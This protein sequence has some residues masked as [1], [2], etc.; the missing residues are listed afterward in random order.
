MRA[1]G[2]D[3]LFVERGEAPSFYDVDGNATSTSCAP[4]AADPRPTGAHPPFL[5]AVAG[6]MVKGTTFVA[7]TAGE[8]EHAEL[9]DA[10]MPA[11]TA[12]QDVFGT[13]AP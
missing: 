3:P 6:A 7:A 13:E 5:E 8:V 2:R 11:W 12:A 9:V 10:R 1:I 4:G